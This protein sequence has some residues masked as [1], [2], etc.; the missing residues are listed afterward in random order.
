MDHKYISYTG[1]KRFFYTRILKQ[2]NLKIDK[3]NGDISNTKIRSVDTIET[4]FPIPAAGET[5]KQFLGKVLTFL[6]NIKPLESNV[7]YYV[8]T[9]GSDAN[10]GNSTSPFKSIKRALDA[11]PKNLGGQTATINIDDGTYDEAIT[12]NGYHSGMV[13]IKSVNSPE[14]LNTLCRIKKA[15]VLN[16]DAR[17]Q[18][19][20]LY[21]TQTDDVALSVTSCNMVYVRCCQAIESATSS[22]AFDFTYATARLSSCKSLNH[23]S[24]IRAY[25]SDIRSENW[26]ESSATEW[27]V[28]I[29]GC[30]LS[31]V[32]NQPS[33]VYGAET[34]QEGGIFVSKYG[35]SIGTLPSDTTIYVSNTGNDA[36]GS[37][38]STSPYRT[39]KY[40]IS[41]IPRDLGGY[42]ATIYIADGTYDEHVNIFGYCGG[43]IILRRNGVQELNSLCNVN[44]IR[45]EYCNSVSISG[46]NLT[47]TKGTS[48]FANMCSFINMAHC[49]SIVATET[50][51]V[52]FNFDYVAVGRIAGCRS[53][54]HNMCLRSFSSNVTSNSW[55]D[56]SQGNYGIFSDGG[57]RVSYGNKFQPRGSMRDSGGY[58]GGTIIRDNGTQISGLVNSGLSCTWGT[59]S[60]GIV[61]N[62]ITGGDGMITVQLRIQTNTTLT[63]GNDYVVTGFPLP[64]ISIGASCSFASTTLTCHITPDGILH[65]QILQNI[66]QNTIILFNCTYLTNS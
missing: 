57:G 62:G 43:Y 4:K 15:T 27:G 7:S 64:P 22:Y 59:I 10:N 53:L 25:T 30:K 3:T 66:S 50:D 45:V 41:T 37:G 28:S 61:R 65:W 29:S 9:F 31:K 24:C 39:I 36:T 44:S 48:I 1:L 52:S 54:N 2:I 58:G 32:G 35:S 12:V 23:K 13:I 21:F 47:N 55:S 8:A 19:H 16:C 51:E 60:G 5:A 18:L 26:A 40:A 6:K 17:I 38:S 63:A 49:Q 42:T 34:V 14:A 20:G 33:G 56:D 46:F 11:I